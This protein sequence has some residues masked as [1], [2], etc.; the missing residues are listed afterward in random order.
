MV[1]TLYPNSKIEFR[2]P[3]QGVVA[4]VRGT[5]FDINL[6]ANYIASVHHGVTLRNRIGQKNL[7]MA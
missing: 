6:D 5:V 7:L 3:K 2:L 4:G 1:R